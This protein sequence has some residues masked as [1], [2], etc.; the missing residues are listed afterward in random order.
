MAPGGNFDIGLAGSDASGITMFNVRYIRGAMPEEDRSRVVVFSQDGN[1]VAESL[2][3]EDLIMYEGAVSAEVRSDSPGLEIVVA[4][5]SGKVYLLSEQGSLLSGW[6]VQM[7]G[8]GAGTPSVADLDGDGVM[9]VLTTSTDGLVYA[10]DPNGIVKRSLFG[11]SRYGFPRAMMSTPCFQPLPVSPLPSW[12]ATSIFRCTSPA[13]RQFDTDPDLEI[14]MDAGAGS[15]STN[16]IH[17]WDLGPAP[18]RPARVNGGPRANPYSPYSREPVNLATANYTLQAMD[19]S[20]PGM[21]PPL[22]FARSYNS[23]GATDGP[24]GHGWL[25]NYSVRLQFS[26]PDPAIADVT[27][28]QEEGR[29]D[30]Y[31]VQPD[32]TYLAPLGIFD[33]LIH[34]PLDGSFDLTRKDKTVLH[35][36]SNGRLLSI[37]DRNGNVTD[38]TYSGGNLTSVLPAARLPSSMMRISASLQSRTQSAASSDMLM[39]S[40]ATL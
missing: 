26:H 29:Q 22:V 11:N 39:T 21:G 5:M 4:G 7:D 8:R 24:L 33:V 31:L 9:E 38:L 19:M 15:P 32:G 40:T 37:E 13:V 36:D 35:F 3:L 1:I 23:I 10:W 17:M 28:I 16:A 2:D 6:P 25:H 12:P 18:A 14:L 30:L 34:D 27:V 20:I